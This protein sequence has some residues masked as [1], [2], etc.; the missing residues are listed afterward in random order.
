MAET[1]RFSVS[2]DAELLAL[3]LE[4]CQRHGYDNRSEALRDLIRESLVQ[5]E[6]KAD[7]EIVGTITIIFDHHKPELTERLNRVQH[8]FHDAILSTLH[9]HLD[10]DN[11]LE[12]IAVKG[13]A[14]R[15]Q[16]V[17]DTLIGTRG[18][19]H[20]KLSATTTGRKLR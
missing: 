19:K 9:V 10:H 2:M 12:I 3:F 13:V 15:V 8:D 17:A 14:S 16:K 18:V 5:D 4:R 7:A 11:C 20:G 1:T 6:W